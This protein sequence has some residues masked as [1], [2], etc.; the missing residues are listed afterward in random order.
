MRGF[1]NIGAIGCFAVARIALI[2]RHERVPVLKIIEL[3]GFKDKV[4]GAKFLV[5]L[6]DP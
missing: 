6:F 5:I 1:M 2:G 3:S 4:C